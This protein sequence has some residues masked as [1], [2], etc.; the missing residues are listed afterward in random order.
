MDRFD[1]S[2]FGGLIIANDC[3]G[4]AFFPT[5]SISFSSKRFFLLLS[6]SMKGS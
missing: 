2:I 1:L 3:I 4:L 6:M 5:S